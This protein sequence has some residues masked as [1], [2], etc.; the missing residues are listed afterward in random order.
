MVGAWLAGRGGSISFSTVASW[1]HEPHL[2]MPPGL[3]AALTPLVVGDATFFELLE[4]AGGVLSS[5]FS[6]PRTWWFTLFPTHC[7]LNE[8]HHLYQS[9]AKERRGSGNRYAERFIARNQHP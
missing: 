3:T 9:G 8:L 4:W 1:V 5:S 6:W 7:V 2:C